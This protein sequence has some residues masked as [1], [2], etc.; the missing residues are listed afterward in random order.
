ME[1]CQ[2]TVISAS[3][4]LTNLSRES[5]AYNTSVVAGCNIHLFYSDQSEVYMDLFSKT[6]QIQNLNIKDL[7]L[8][9]Q[10]QVLYWCHSVTLLLILNVCHKRSKL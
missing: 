1:F 6:F 2:D 9:S 10:P 5:Y 7:I 3:C 8:A 4:M